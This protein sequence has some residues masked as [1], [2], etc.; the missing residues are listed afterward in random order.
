[1]LTSTRA[2]QDPPRR[3][4]LAGQR[5]LEARRGARSFGLGARATPA[6][7]ASELEAVI[8]AQGHEPTVALIV[9]ND[10]FTIAHRLEIVSLATCYR[11]PAVY[12]FR[13]F[14]ELGNLIPTA[15]T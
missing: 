9:L 5:G 12:P 8:A 7:D 15:S 13:F 6:R 2:E 11:L 10:D 1:V 14:A 4:S 3:D